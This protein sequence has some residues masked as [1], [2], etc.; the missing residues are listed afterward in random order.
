MNTNSNTQAE[1]LA[2]PVLA[3][4]FYHTFENCLYAKSE[5]MKLGLKEEDFYLATEEYLEIGFLINEPMVKT[6]DD[7][8]KSALDMYKEK[9]FLNQHE[10]TLINIHLKEIE[11]EE[12]EDTI[13]RCKKC[14]D[15]M[16]HLFDKMACYKCMEHTP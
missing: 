14:G 8:C 1:N 11:S 5:L 10:K 4:R 9:M 13:I 6:N 12:E 3:N 2:K 16:Y 7:F 15:K